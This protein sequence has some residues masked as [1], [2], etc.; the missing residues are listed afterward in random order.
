MHSDRLQVTSITSRAT[1][2][3]I[4]HISWSTGQ[5]YLF[6]S[7]DTSSSHCVTMRLFIHDWSAN[8]H[9][10]MH[11]HTFFLVLSTCTCK[12]K[13]LLL[14]FA[15]LT[16]FNS[17]FIVNINFFFSDNNFIHS[18]LTVWTLTLSL[19]LMCKGILVCVKNNNFNHDL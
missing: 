14:I 7:L 12:L 18:L 17:C 5:C 6:I 10:L 2:I 16:G 1:S 9:V 8:K 11:T 4:H 13:L 3:S 15:L 19:H